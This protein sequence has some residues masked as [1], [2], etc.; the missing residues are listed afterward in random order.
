MNT[1]RILIIVVI[2]A[3]VVGGFF[4][5]RSIAS[6]RA[7]AFL[8][9]DLQTE[10]AVMGSLEALVGATGTVR[11]NQSVQLSWQT[12]GTVDEVLASVGDLVAEG[13]KLATLR[14]SS[15]PQNVILAQA[16]L[17][18]AQNALD[19]LVDGYGDLSIALAEKSVAD[20]QLRYEDALE[21]VGDINWTGDEDEIDKAYNALQ[22]AYD[23]LKTAEAKKDGIG[24]TNSRSYR[25]AYFNYLQAYDEY[26]TKLGDYNYL[27]GKTVDETERSIAEADL[28]V[29]QQQL[30]EA[31]ADL[32]KLLAGPDHEDVAAAEARIAAAQSALELA[33]IDAPFTGTVTL[34][35]SK[36]GDTAQVGL[37]VFRVDDLSSLLV[38]VDI[39]EVDIN[40]VKIGQPVY[41]TFDAILA[42]E[43]TGEVI[44]VSPVG[45]SSAGL[46][47]FKVTIKLNDA[48]ENVRP[49]MTAAVN[50][51]VS[52]LENALLV[53]NRA[54]R[55]INGERV[56]YT[57]TNGELKM[58]TIVLGAS[59][60]LYSEV[61]SGDLQAGDMVVLNPPA[62]IFS[63]DGPP[64][65]VRQ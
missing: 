9:G 6:N 58:V 33:W 45:N 2:L 52:E 35:D 23:K 14:Q 10:K 37:P 17:V 28:A 64:A 27:A 8:T 51:V 53:P 36:P 16:D 38:D 7:S 20:A 13:E 25:L 43:Y 22:L 48:D 4:A 39:S 15:L 62:D 47:N 1:R 55:V 32:A 5:L 42:S 56:I 46:V 40:R 26:A 18:S 44:E 11:A 19:D 29:A 34:A 65:F 50:V 61:I 41:L 3:V 24:N 31:E 60:D 54:V 21:Y 12:S 63:M 30:A 57:L 59:S 49:G